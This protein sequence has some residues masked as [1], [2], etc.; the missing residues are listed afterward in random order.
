MAFI[1][2]AEALALIKASPGRFYVYILRKPDGTPIY[3]GKGQRR[4]IAHHE[5]DARKS[6]RHAKARV[7][8]A[9]WKRGNAVSYELIG[10]YE[11]EDAAFSEECKLIAT[12]GRSE[13]GTGPLLNQTDGGEGP[14]GRK[15][16][17]ET[18]AKLKARVFS[19]EAR[20]AQAAWLRSDENERLRL[21]AEPKRI[22]AV[23]EALR[24]D[25]YRVAKSAQM[26]EIIQNN[27]DLLEARISHLAHLRSDPEMRAVYSQASKASWSD[28]EK[29]A[30]RLAA[31][32]EA[33]NRPELIARRSEKSR[34]MHADPEFKAKHIER[35][36]AARL[37]Y[38]EQKADRG[39][40]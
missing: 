35:C 27:P 36:R 33:A 39:T 2:L 30:K 5:E 17:P 21:A 28:P 31:L 18:R 3:V 37:R 25:S 6:T 40:G 15:V 9:I 19:Q 26:K 32:K 16:G 34:A 1:T 4:R 23:A 8:R 29:R 11:S 24:A 12:T 14:I 20:A 13:L 10:F 38:L 7:I 22:K